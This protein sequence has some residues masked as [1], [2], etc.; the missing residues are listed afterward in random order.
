MAR[1]EI[2]PLGLALLEGFEDV[3]ALVRL[4]WDRLNELGANVAAT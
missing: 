4:V 2:N 1:S 3:T